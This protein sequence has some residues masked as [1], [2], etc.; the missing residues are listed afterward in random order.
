MN[1][2]HKKGNLTQGTQHTKSLK[3]THNIFDLKNIWEIWSN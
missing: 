2:G 3:L 1:E